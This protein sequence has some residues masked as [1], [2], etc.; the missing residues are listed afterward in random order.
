MKRNVFISLVTSIFVLSL[1]S[2][3][4]V[5]TEPDDLPHQLY[6]EA[7]NNNGFAGTYEEWL[8]SIKGPKGDKGDK[9]DTGYKGDTGAEG[10]T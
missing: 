4:V 5:A 1:A 3:S 8:E 10:P 9:G 7:V 6:K 2:C